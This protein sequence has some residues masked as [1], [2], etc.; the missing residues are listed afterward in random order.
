MSPTIGLPPPPPKD[1]L[2]QSRRSRYRGGTRIAEEVCDLSEHLVRLANADLYRPCECAR[3]GHR[4]LH[5]HDRVERHPVGDASLPPAVLVL[6]FRC[7]LATCGATWRILPRFL[8]RHLWYAWRAVEQTMRPTDRS[9]P[10][11]A[12]E[13]SE[14]TRQRWQARLASSGR[15]LVV[16]LAMAGGSLGE[17]AV[18]VSLSCT[19]GELLDAFVEHVRPSPGMQL[20]ALAAVVHRLERGVRL[21]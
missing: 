10:A 9:E 1:I 18:E 16:L 2:D 7:A 15:T 12:P 6:V 11:T 19:R 21:M 17:L 14:S 5:V 3:C 20:S 4:T 13:I 8:A